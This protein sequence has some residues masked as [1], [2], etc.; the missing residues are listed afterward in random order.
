MCENNIEIIVKNMV[1][2]RCMKVVNDELIKHDI[3]FLKVDLG[4]I[5][6]NKPL[7]GK[8]LGKI[9]KILNKEGFE[10]LKD[11]NRQLVNKVKSLIINHIHY[12]KTPSNLNLSFFISE[13]LGID[14]TSISKIFSK[15]EGQTI[16]QFV[17]QQ[18]IERVKELLIYNELTLS[19]I[20]YE[21]NYS[22]PQYLSRQFKQVTGMNPSEF[23]KK[24][25]RKRLDTI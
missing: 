22:S 9:E 8:T 4:K 7:D 11:K 19:Q 18:R 13:K 16:E 20:S 21:L 6:F 14:Y 23:K 5:Y 3:P 10:L 24:G 17:I 2:N 25:T 15:T 1:C 12:D